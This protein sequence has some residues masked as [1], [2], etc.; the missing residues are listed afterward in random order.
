MNLLEANGRIE[1]LEID[2]AAKYGGRLILV[3]PRKGGS[4][5]LYLVG[6][7]FYMFSVTS[8]VVFV[9]LAVRSTQEFGL[10]CMLVILPMMVLSGVMTPIENMPSLIRAIMFLLPTPHFV[11]FSADVAFRASGLALVWPSLAAMGAIGLTF[12]IGALSVFGI[13]VSRGNAQSQFNAT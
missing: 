11:R 8:I 13:P 10:I 7:A 2:L 5:P 9:S 4:V 6:A 3:V 1:A 12:M